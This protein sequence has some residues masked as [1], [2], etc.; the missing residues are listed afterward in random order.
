[1]EAAMFKRLVS[2]AV[3]FM[4]VA[5]CGLRTAGATTWVVPEQEQMLAG[6]DAVVLATVSG[7][8]SVAA[9]DGS[10]VN[11]EVTLRVHE[12]FKGASAGDQLTLVQ[13]GGRVG[14]QQQWIFGSPEYAMG[15]TVLVYLKL[16]PDGVLRTHNLALGKVSA[17]VAN[18]GRVWLSRVA[19]KGFGRRIE[20]LDHF[21]HNVAPL[22]R[23]AQRVQAQAPQLFGTTQATTQFRLMEPASRWFDLPV[24]VFGD[25]AGDSKLGATASRQAVVDSSAAWSGRPGSELTMKY[26]GDRTGSGFQ[27]VQGA[28]T[29]TFD[30]PRNEVDDPSGCS[31]VLA[32][33][34]FCSSG[35]VRG[36]TSYQTINSGSIVFN[37]GW[38]G[39]NF[40][41]KTDF[42]NFEEV[43]THEM[44][45]AIGLAHSSDGTSGGTFT[46]DA[47]MYWM[48]HFD[49]RGAGLKDYDNG[50]IAYLY[51]NG[52]AAPTPAPTAKPTP[53]PTAKP[54]PT[55]T[56]RPAATPTPPVATPAPTPASTD[57]DGDGVRNSKDNCPAVANASQTD[58]DADG[59]G[60]A[61]DSCPDLANQSANQSCTLL[62]GKAT[63]TTSPGRDEGG[64]VLDGAFSGVV[65][66]RTVGTLRF[67]FTGSNG[68]YAVDVPAGA[69]KPNKQGTVA[70]YNSKALSV[71][72]RRAS[73]PGML[74]TARVMASQVKGLVGSTLGARVVLPNNS[75]A[76]SLPC[77]TREYGSRAVTQ[78]QVQRSSGGTRNIG[79]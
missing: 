43:M 23:S 27:C 76:M 58:R 57:I 34:G 55:P 48:A 20:S 18:N 14:D 5:L 52:G 19:P 10:Q 53:A 49:G 70:T 28:M 37:N 36:G 38:G 62:D 74:V 78:C 41:S 35:S 26:A 2:G 51:D 46:S 13:T 44:G 4:L 21:T 25:I 17:R 42:R 45:H 59:V 15:E 11:T 9:F 22:A 68:T 32:V 75:A 50:A 6:A 67:E 77:A 3:V 73:T 64:L 12:G 79:G 66:T 8:R 39:C 33:G 31:G 30:D 24:Q 47:T 7:L 54:A 16:G 40:W 61:C 69:L 1:M 60:D 72:L 65:D 29:I 71:T 63:I 56:P